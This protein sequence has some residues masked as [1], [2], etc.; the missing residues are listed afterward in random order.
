[1]EKFTLRLKKATKENHTK[2]DTHEFVK[3]LY[4]EYND[5]NALYYL[6][7]HYIILKELQKLINDTESDSI[8]CF[9]YFDKDYS[10]FKL[11]DLGELGSV[12]GVINKIREDKN[13][14]VLFM[15]HLYIWWLGVL[16]GGQM[17][18]KLLNKNEELMEYIDVMFNF[19]CN[20]RDLI[21][22]FKDYLN[23][24]ISSDECE[25]RFIK[26]VNE[27]YL[28]IGKVFDEIINKMK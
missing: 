3:G 15:S 27:V 9:K 22:D 19:E 21:R 14:D 28:M 6:E 8:D 16:F 10:I 17:I 18:K 26:N 2:L 20:S 7:L 13:D 25:E 12:K 4:K 24:L 5:K 1:M 23:E 11:S